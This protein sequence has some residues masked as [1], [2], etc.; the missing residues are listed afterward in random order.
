MGSTEI[1]GKHTPTRL[2]ESALDPNARVGEITSRT[3]RGP[4][5]RPVRWRPRRILHHALLRKLEPPR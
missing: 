2:L 3:E 5:L 4:Q 1:C